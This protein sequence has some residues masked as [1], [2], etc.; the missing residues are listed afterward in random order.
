M[1]YL[2]NILD[3]ILLLILRMDTCVLNCL[4]L[5]ILRIVLHGNLLSRR[6]CVLSMNLLILLRNFILLYCRHRLNHNGL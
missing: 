3:I 1:L 5:E 2:R 6:H 4:R